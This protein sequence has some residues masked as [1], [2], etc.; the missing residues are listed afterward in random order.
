[1]STKLQ[2]TLIRNASFDYWLHN[3]H[4]RGKGELQTFI[5]KLPEIKNTILQ[6][7]ELTLD[8]E[9]II[10]DAM[11]AVDDINSMSKNWPARMLLLHKHLTPEQ[12]SQAERNKA[13]VEALN[14]RVTLLLQE[15]QN[16]CATR[17]L[18]W[19]TLKESVIRNVNQNRRT[20][21]A[22]RRVRRDLQMLLLQLKEAASL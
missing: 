2:K 14:E 4:E 17:S 19:A 7:G 15:L 11:F 10:Y 6:A 1:M 8:D 16:A 18:S 21:R 22:N 20:P 3:G 12:I 13:A 5:D 9:T